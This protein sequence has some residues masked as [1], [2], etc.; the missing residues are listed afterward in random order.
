MEEEKFDATNWNRKSGVGEG[1]SG[2]LE[3]AKGT[4]CSSRKEE[5]LSQWLSAGHVAERSSDCVEEE[6][7]ASWKIRPP[8][9]E[10]PH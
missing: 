2:C 9:P 6:V 1:T 7:T 5:E 10:K 3:W 8:G 4:A